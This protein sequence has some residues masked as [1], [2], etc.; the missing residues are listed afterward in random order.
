V[1]EAIRDN[2]ADIHR[3]G[4]DHWQR[5]ESDYQSADSLG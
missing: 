4:I 1:R 3:R 2:I 5:Q